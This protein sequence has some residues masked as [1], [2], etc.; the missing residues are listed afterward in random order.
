[1]LLAAPVNAWAVSMIPLKRNWLRT[2]LI[3][4]LAA[5][6]AVVA[7]TRSTLQFREDAADLLM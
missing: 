2:L 3:A 7:A 6:P 5:A 1:M 4:V